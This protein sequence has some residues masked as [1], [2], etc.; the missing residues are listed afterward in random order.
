M[1]ASFGTSTIGTNKFSIYCTYKANTTL[2]KE[3]T[4]SENINNN[5][6]QAH[7]VENDIKSANNSSVEIS[8]NSL[9]SNDFKL[10]PNPANSFVNVDYEFLPENGIIIEILDIN[11]KKVHSQTAQQTSNRLDINYLK[12]GMYIIRS[13]NGKSVNVKKLIVE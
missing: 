3:A 12:P 10:Y 11:G 7:S 8:V 5:S 6:L 2:L 13:T 9:E 4:I 1:P